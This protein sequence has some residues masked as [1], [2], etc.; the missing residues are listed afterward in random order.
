M[1]GPPRLKGPGWPGA[2]GGSCARSRMIDTGME[3]NSLRGGV[4]YTIGRH[5]PAVAERPAH[6]GQGTLL[7][8][9]VDEADP[10]DD[11]VERPGRKRV[12][13]LPVRF[14]GLD[15]G[16]PGFDGGL[17]GVGED[18]GGD[19]GGHDRAGRADPAGRRQGLAARSGRHVEHAGAGP[20]RR[21][22]RAWARWPGRASPPAS[23]PNGARPRRRPPTAPGWWSCTGSDRS[24]S[25]SSSSRRTSS[26]RWAPDR[27]RIAEDPA[28]H[29]A[30]RQPPHRKAT[31]GPCPS[32]PVPGAG[33]S[34]RWL[35]ATSCST[36]S[37]CWSDGRWLVSG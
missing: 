6:A 16:Q 34:P 25:V 3:K 22:R 4:E 11:R 2:G 1:P 13:R 9:E 17:G 33:W 35:V 21:P 31:M 24:P 7:V 14:E 26:K 20:R 8:G 29:F 27:R 23:A 12:E 37:A 36:G 18:R 19:V 10:A 30:R 5:P 32:P 28:W 15:V